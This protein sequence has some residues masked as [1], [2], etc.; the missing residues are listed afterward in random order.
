M[1]TV[2]WGDAF[3]ICRAEDPSVSESGQGHVGIH[4]VTC[5]PS[6]PPEQETTLWK[7]LFCLSR[8]PDDTSSVPVQKEKAD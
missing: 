6:G 7:R 5:L 1:N 8:P 4:T 3:S 2:H